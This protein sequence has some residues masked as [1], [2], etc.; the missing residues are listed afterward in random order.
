M[1][2]SLFL[3]GLSSFSE[4]YHHHCTPLSN[5]G[6]GA[7]AGSSGQ[8][9]VTAGS[10]KGSKTSKVVKVPINEEH[11]RTDEDKKS[12]WSYFAENAG[13]ILKSLVCMSA[14]ET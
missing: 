6:S 12:R 7:V 3:V 14:L 4:F 9:A 10:K 1:S 5:S 11:F 2:A 13:H 8:S